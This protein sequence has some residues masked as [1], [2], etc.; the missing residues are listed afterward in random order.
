MISDPSAHLASEDNAVHSRHRITLAADKLSEARKTIASQT[1]SG[2]KGLQ[3]FALQSD[4]IDGIVLSVYKAITDELPLYQLHLLEGR[5][6]LV[7]LGGYGRREMAPFSDIDLMV[8]HDGACGDVVPTVARR[9]VQDLFD[10]GLQ[11][12]QSV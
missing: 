4:L 11:V 7:A 10:A 3:T 2:A 9:L 12:G 1:A 8:L 5:V 6:A